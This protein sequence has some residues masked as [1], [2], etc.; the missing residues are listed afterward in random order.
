LDELFE[1]AFEANS[2]PEPTLA[3]RAKSYSDFY[4]V[5]KAQLHK[6]GTQKKRKKSGKK[7]RREICS[8]EALDVPET[9]RVAIGMEDEPL[10]NLYKDE[11]LHASQQKYQCVFW[12][13]TPISHLELI[14][15][16]AVP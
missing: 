10:L 11:L 16:K 2:P 9:G 13:C 3:R 8:V 14:W 1:D 12:I 4:E 15:T 5:V 7:S 6:D